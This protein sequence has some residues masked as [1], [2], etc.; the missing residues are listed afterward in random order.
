MLKRLFNF[1][2]SA[3]HLDP[4]IIQSFGRSGST[5]LMRM[6]ATSPETIFEEKYPYE[7]RHLTYLMRACNLIDIDFDMIGVKPNYRFNLHSE[8][9]VESEGN[10]KFKELW[11]RTCKKMLGNN[12]EKKYYVEKSVRLID[13]SSL[14]GKL[15]YKII[16]IIRDPRDIVLSIDKF[17][18]KRGYLDFSWNKGETD[19]DYS[20]KNI[21]SFESM[22]NWIDNTDPNIFTVK[23][24]D[25]VESPF[26]EL[27]RVKLWLDI[28]INWVPSRRAEDE[29][30]KKHG[31][32]SAS[33]S[34]TYQWKTELGTEAADY[35]TE[36]LKCELL[37][38]GYP[39]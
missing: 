19:L 38:A 39:L 23:Y 33:L 30:L 9:K 16:R 3:N 32:S 37:R 7:T 27:D 18:K 34:P 15:N 21:S 36:T 17:N 10:D 8:K 4:I 35:L 1:K 28:Q 12:K 24:E 29:I 11:A 25:L 20:R 2:N 5:L 14:K 6:L 22:L 26:S 13:Y 31:T